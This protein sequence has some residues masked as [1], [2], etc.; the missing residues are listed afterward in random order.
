MFFL[1][2]FMS[3]GPP[4]GGEASEGSFDTLFGQYPR[5]AKIFATRGQNSCGAWPKL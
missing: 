2:F 4:P 1:T 5:V 3:L